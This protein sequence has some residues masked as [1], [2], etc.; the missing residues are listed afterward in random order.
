MNR[1]GLIVRL[2]A[3]IYDPVI[4]EFDVVQRQMTTYPLVEANSNM[5]NFNATV[6]AELKQYHESCGF[7][8]YIDKYLQFPPP[9]KQPPMLFNRSD[10]ASLMCDLFDGVMYLEI[11]VNP[12]FNVY[13]VVSQTHLLC[14]LSLLFGSG[15]ITAMHNRTVCVPCYGM[16]L[17]CP[18]DLTTLPDLST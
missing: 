17:E 11:Q 5:F 9:E 12:C 16:F 7:K 8:D 3:L 10:N 14:K 6:M 18:L 15:L 4:G 13:E 1:V 2:G